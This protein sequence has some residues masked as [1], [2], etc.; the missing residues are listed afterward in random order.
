MPTSHDVEEDEA[1]SSVAGPPPRRRWMRRMEKDCRAHVREILDLVHEA[2]NARLYSNYRFLMRRPIYV[3]SS[4]KSEAIHHIKGVDSVGRSP[5]LG[6]SIPVSL[7][8]LETDTEKE[9]HV[10]MPR[11]HKGIEVSFAD[12]DQEEI[13]HE[14]L[15]QWKSFLAEAEQIDPVRQSP[16]SRR[17]LGRGTRQSLA[18]LQAMTR[19]DWNTIDA[20]DYI[21][22]DDEALDIVGDEVEDNFPDSD[23]VE[24]S[25]FEE[26]TLA[27]IE[28]TLN[29]VHIGDLDLDTEDFNLLLCRATCAVDISPDESLKLLMTIFENM[30]HDKVESRHAAD[31]MTSEIM[32]L[33]L[34]ERHGSPYAALRLAKQLVSSPS[35]RTADSMC[36]ALRLCHQLN[37]VTTSL[38]LWSSYREEDQAAYDLPYDALGT[39][40]RTLRANF[41][42]ENAMEV[43]R[44]AAKVNSDSTSPGL[45]ILFKAVCAWPPRSRDGREDNTKILEATLE[46]LV[47]EPRYQ[48]SFAVWRGLIVAASKDSESIDQ[49]R[50]IVHAALK[51]LP[52]KFEDY[53]PDPILMKIGLDTCHAVDDPCLA[54]DLIARRLAHVVFRLEKKAESEQPKSDEVGA[55]SSSKYDTSDGSVQSIRV[56]SQEILKAMDICADSE[57][58]ETV[59]AI[60]SLV[61]EYEGAFHFSLYRQIA[62][63]AIE[64]FIEHGKVE[65]A[66]ALVERLGERG[67]VPR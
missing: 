33:A 29:L 46:L 35:L 43:L 61:E 65:S 64:S 21:P 23:Q 15:S 27:A 50:H 48:P 6:T 4:T 42:Q 24:S 26:D 14:D 63:I 28:T 2:G 56:S 66:E 51:E 55:L 32:I 34:S 45:D 5:S 57:E 60:M 53:W 44:H 16:P 12:E 25:A 67:L 41:L 38:K 9:P 37:E 8:S 19:K 39:L 52:S 59:Q 11:D 20:L 22:D 17:L 36:A 54:V 18:L 58:V 13:E 10:D 7:V 47:T 49:R 62:S 1:I 30:G 31:S 40:V 3:P